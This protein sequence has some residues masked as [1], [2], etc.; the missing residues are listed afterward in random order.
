MF[1]HSILGLGNMRNNILR[2][3]F[4]QHKTD[5]Q[6]FLKMLSDVVVSVADSCSLVLASYH[7]MLLNK[8]LV[9]VASF[10]LLIRIL[11]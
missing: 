4:I 7:H 3:K 5:Y 2:S 1:D 9:E 11:Y 8:K 10:T 6:D